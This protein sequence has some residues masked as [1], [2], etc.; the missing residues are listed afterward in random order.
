MKRISFVFFLAFCTGGFLFAQQKNLPATWQAMLKR[1][2]GKNIHFTFEERKVNSKP[3]I[4]IKN[5]KERIRV[6]NITRAGDSLL[7]RMPVF[8]SSFS[9]KTS[10]DKWEGTWTRGTAGKDLMMPFEAMRSSSR[11]PLVKGIAKVN[12]SGRWAVHFSSDNSTAATSIAEFVQ[13]GNTV[14]GTFLTPTGDYRFLEGVVTGDSLILSGFDG[15]HAVL[16]EGHIAGGKAITNGH[17]YSGVKFTEEWSAVKNAKA[18]VKIDESAM[19]VRSGEK[20]LDFRFPDLDSNMVS[21]S[22]KRFNGKVTVV[23][24]MG[25]WC[26]NCMDETAFLTEYYAKNKQRGVEMVALAYEYSTDFE[27]SKN[28]LLK[29]KNRFN[30]N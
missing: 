16:F 29:F 30:V 3:I 14:T 10:P 13:K 12:V 15:A 25:S 20:Q 5:A 28:S 21:L 18:T 11:Y 6:E 24:L 17:Y 2:D 7:I 26:P 22:D 1:P 23:Q 19:Y 4:T 27:R 9:I 8:E